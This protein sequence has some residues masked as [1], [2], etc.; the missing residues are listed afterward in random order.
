MNAAS[1]HRRPAVVHDDRPT[2]DWDREREK[3]RRILD[4]TRFKPT[5]SGHQP[6]AA[7][8][9]W[10]CVDNAACEIQL[11]LVEQQQKLLNQRKQQASAS[12]SQISSHAGRSDGWD[13][14]HSV[15]GSLDNRTAD[16]KYVSANITVHSKSQRELADF[17]HRV[18]SRDDRS[19]SLDDFR[20][21]LNSSSRDVSAYNKPAA[22]DIPAAMMAVV[23]GP[24][25]GERG[26]DAN[27]EQM[28][29]KQKRLYHLHG[30]EK[31]GNSG[32]YPFFRY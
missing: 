14:N 17:S 23:D 12:K 10:P 11:S 27:E 2:D 15:L 16:E 30:L 13:R 24:L 32:F 3:H 1:Q 4:E 20:S 26:F 18:G 25:V 7:E 8:N 19:R 22:A 29:K 5:G 28:R 31:S 6:P 9:S 21:D